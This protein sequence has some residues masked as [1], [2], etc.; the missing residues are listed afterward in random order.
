MQINPTS[1]LRM[2][3]R[4][5]SLLLA[6]SVLWGG[7]FFFIRIAQQDL[8]TLMV[9]WLRVGVSALALNVL[10]AI[11]GLR[12]PSDARTWTA[13]AGM[14][15]L[16]NALPFTL[17]V[18]GE[19]HI[20]SGLT[21]MLNATTPLFTAVVA[22]FATDDEKLSVQRI[23]GLI[24]GFLGVAVM[25]GPGAISEMHAKTL[26]QL[27]VLAA[28]LSYACSGVY[29]RRFRRM[30]VAP[31]VTATGQVTVSTIL[32]APVALIV[33]HPWN[34]PFPPQDVLAAIAGLALLSTALAYIIYFRI[35]AASGATNL[36]LV[37]MLI[38]VTAILLGVLVLNEHIHSYQI[39]GMFLVGC[40]LVTMDG[41][42]IR[43]AHRLATPHRTVESV[44][45]DVQR[46]R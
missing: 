32:L 19:N 25:I 8:P 6:L 27:A 11:L 17:I 34:L 3:T 41:R 39:A 15:F 23:I 4:E 42:A 18:W 29:G 21:S 45:T 5:W 30:G 24:V 2:G 28:A 35:L 31:L 9:V 1:S 43:V 36:L 38:P 16:N 22:H 46:K 20:G 14:G 13:F 26:S 37:T 12:M 7:S 44:V 33:D 40:G 10:I